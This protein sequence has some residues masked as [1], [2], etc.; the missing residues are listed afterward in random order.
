MLYPLSFAG[1]AM[2]KNLDFDYMLTESH[3]KCF[4]QNGGRGADHFADLSASCCA[5]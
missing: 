5:T 3:L 2:E 4:S 1:S